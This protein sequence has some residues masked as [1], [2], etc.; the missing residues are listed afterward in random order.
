M[1]SRPRRPLRLGAQALVLQ[2]VLSF[3]AG[4][5]A[6]ARAQPHADAG[7]A[8]HASPSPKEPS[9]GGVSTLKRLP[10][11]AQLSESVRARLEQR[12]ARHAA[13]LSQDDT[14]AAAA[15]AATAGPSDPSGEPLRRG[16]AYQRRVQALDTGRGVTEL[17]NRLVLP[18][19]RLMLSA[20]RSAP[21]APEPD[22]PLEEEADEPAL[23]EATRVTETHSLRSLAS[24]PTKVPPAAA[25]VSWLVWPFLLFLLGGA[26]VGTLWFRKKTR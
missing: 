7:V 8:Q 16:E 2:A 5:V 12:A 14:A 19:P 17:S 26:V 15:E 1:S 25:G 10:N 4:Q 3:T 6:P 24:R 18:E 20:Q 21:A 23:V 11:S 9:A 22:A 13:N